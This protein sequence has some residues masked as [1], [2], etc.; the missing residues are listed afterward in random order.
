VFKND[1]WCNTVK[2][3][4]KAIVERTFCDMSQNG[5]VL[6]TFF[7]SDRPHCLYKIDG[8]VSHTDNLTLSTL[9]YRKMRPYW[10]LPVKK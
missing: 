9:H 10:S 6:D 7:K 8:L 5:T 4:A 2:H 3:A 1:R